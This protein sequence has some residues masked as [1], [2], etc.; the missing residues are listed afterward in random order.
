MRVVVVLE[1]RF[2]QTPD[3][4]VWTDGPGEYS[5]WKRYLE[6]FEDVR[7]VARVMAAADVRAGLLRADGPRVTFAPVPHY[8]GPWAYLGKAHAVRRAVRKAIG[9]ADAVILRVPSNLAALAFPSLRRD[10]R[11][12]AVE[13]LGDPYDV[14]APGAVR[15]PLRPWFRAMFVRALRR[16]CRHA[17]AAAYVTA[18]ALQGRYPT[19]P[20]AHCVHYSDVQIEGSIVERPR[21]A[22]CPSPCGLVLVGGLG[23]WNKAPDVLLD[24]VGQ[25]A[26]DGLDLRLTIVGDGK[27]RPELES[28]AA[29]LGLRDRV[30]F[31]GQLLGGEA[32]REELDRADLFVLPSRA[33][34]LPRAMIEAMARGLPCLGSTVGGIP[35]LLP[36]EDMVRPND[37]GELARKIREVVTDP[38]R[39]A[40]MS[41]RNL[42][43][44]Q[45]YREDVL[46]HRR[47]AFYQ[48]VRQA[49]ADFCTAS[50][51]P[52]LPLQARSATS[53]EGS[54]SSDRPKA[55]LLVTAAVSVMFVRG[56]AAYLRDRGFEVHLIS[57]A[58]DELQ[59]AHQ[60]GLFTHEVS[61]SRE[62]DL[63]K[64][65]AALYRLVRVFRSLR[66]ELV[67]AATPKAG[68]LGMLA[69]RLNRVPVRVYL[70][71][72]L[73]LETTRGPKRR[74][75]W[76]AERTASACATRVICVSQSLRKLF[77]QLKLAPAGKTVV[78]GAGSSRGVDAARFLATPELRQ[79]A[80]AIR[81]EHGI[82]LDAPV[83]GFIGR[84]TRDKGIEKLLE[85]FELVR[86]RVPAARLLL[87]GDFEPSDPVSAETVRALLSH[88]QIN[89]ATFSDQVEAYFL[90]MDVLAFPSFREGLADVSIEAAAAGLPVVGFAA[91][92]TVDAIVHGVTGTLVPKGDAAAMAESIVRYLEDAELRRAHGAAARQRVL[93]DFRPET[94]WEAL[95]QEYVSLMRQARTPLQSAREC[96]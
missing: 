83:V 35:E 36:P 48:Y 17:C 54:R 26:R 20:S 82:P 80:A 43:A 22:A 88:P 34:G 21:P 44:V 66:P 13:V 74:I 67:V 62:I 32:V 63:R 29:A 38:Q 95:Y 18:A 59:R 96:A 90:A 93:Q 42:Q 85:A 84:L 78:L 65:A 19:G 55:V 24:A 11:P 52:V 28:Q 5:F 14:F 8:L 87:R 77:V 92:G 58:G 15:H 94:V 69:A 33:E 27:H 70:Q 23:H 61:M 41:A 81:S 2:C 57:S 46:C 86:M 56:Q 79:R 68:L 64:D 39:M 10:G 4:C 51:C 76:L 16:H 1:Q 37:A 12:Y 75:L 50:D 91:T 60:D 3:G 72:G 7:V 31:R 89:V 49:T 45:E 73:R 6:V 40:R 47:T 25:C 30:C 53:S 9:P 71:Y